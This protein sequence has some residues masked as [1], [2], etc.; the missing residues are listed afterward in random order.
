[1]KAHGRFGGVSKVVCSPQERSTSIH[2]FI[3]STT[4]K[5]KSLQAA[6]HT[7]DITIADKVTAASVNST[8]D[9]L[10]IKRR[11]NISSSGG[12]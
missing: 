11:I 9:T 2:L 6:V 1:M 5:P 7:I 3:P 12:I 10:V 4:W 8:P